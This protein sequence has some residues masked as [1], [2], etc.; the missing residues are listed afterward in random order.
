MSQRAALKTAAM[1]DLPTRIAEAER[2][3]TAGDAALAAGNPELAYR[4]YTEAHDRVTDCP[5]LHLRAHRQLRRV[6]RQRRPR[7]EYYTDTALLLLAPL[8]IFELIAWVLR[9]KVA[10]AALC[11]RGAASNAG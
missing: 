8:G 4:H 6:T 2:L 1:Q 11:R 10:G 9:S 5:R 3:W 7:G